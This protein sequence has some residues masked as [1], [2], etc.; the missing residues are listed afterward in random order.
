LQW[1]MT[2]LQR[3]I[4]HTKKIWPMYLQINTIPAKKGFTCY[5]RLHLQRK[6]FPTKNWLTKERFHL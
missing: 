2:Y 4:W 5:E 6:I 3:N 1:E